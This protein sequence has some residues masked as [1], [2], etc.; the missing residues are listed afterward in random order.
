MELVPT[1]GEFATKLVGTGDGANFAASAG[2]FLSNVLRVL[3]AG[4]V[5]VKNG[6]QAAS[7]VIVAFGTVV[8]RTLGALVSPINRFTEAIGLAFHHLSEGNFREAANAF[9]NIA[10]QVKQDF[11]D[12]GNAISSVVYDQMGEAFADLTE[13]VDEANEA[14]LGVSQSAESTLPPAFKATELA[15]DDAVTVVGDLNEKV[16]WANTAL[17]DLQTEM[18]DG[19]PAA[20]KDMSEAIAAPSTGMTAVMEQAWQNLDTTFQNV[21]TN[22]FETGK[23]SLDSIKDLFLQTLAQMAHQATRPIVMRLGASMGLGGGAAAGGGLFG[24]GIGAFLGDLAMP[25]AI[26]SMIGGNTPA[27]QWG[28]GIGAVGG[29]FATGAIASGIGAMAASGGVFASI[30]G[31][32]GTQALNFII[33]VI[34]P[35][36]GALLGKA[37]GK[38]LA[39]DPEVTFQGSNFA[40]IEEGSLF[41]GFDVRARGGTGPQED[42][43]S[44]AGQAI[45]AIREFD[46]ALGSFMSENQIA[47]IVEAM[48][49]W[50]VNLK[51]SA[52]TIENI[53]E[54]R[55]GVVLS[56]FSRAA[57]DYVRGFDG[58]EAQTQA[59][60]AY[61][62]SNLADLLAGTTDTLTSTQKLSAMAT[63][64][65][66][67][68]AN[69]DGTPEQMRELA[70][71]IDQRYRAEIEYIQAI[72]A[73]VQQIGASI[74]RQ[75]QQLR[76]M[77]GLGAEEL[78]P[79]Q[80]LAQARTAMAGLGAAGSPEEIAAI[81]SRVQ[82]LVQRAAD[83]AGS[84]PEKLAKG[85][86]G[87]TQAD[88]IRQ[89]ILVLDQLE[90]GAVARADVLR[91]AALAESIALREEAAAF[92]EAQ[93]ISLD[94]V[95][96]NT[97]DT[98][99][100]I[101][102]QT[103]VISDGN[104][105]IVDEMNRMNEKFDRLIGLEQDKSDR[106]VIRESLVPAT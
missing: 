35:L 13:G 72:D 15:I 4:V 3:V 47:K 12:A 16:G 57:Q 37:I 53:L 104:A 71:S 70:I 93:Q 94:D 69:F 44:F 21:W 18:S 2:Q 83:A 66:D 27:E 1:L 10:G 100:A 20:A 80:I 84:L 19:V 73:L 106:D 23:L 46:D 61:A 78:T 31:G 48:K 45:A 95:V 7:H 54:S 14:I 50:R 65:R 9:G 97:G 86:F 99:G 49:G 42:P 34:G 30:L 40:P 87:M 52:V 92:A 32:I 90:R 98:I 96:L 88:A 36:I 41:G 82:G 24:G 17:A 26:G 89:A 25:L 11:I 43:N 63:A 103:V 6:F 22:F 60:A 77:I 79:S 5:I 28:S 33:P 67:I 51:N 81:V 105:A 55:F 101:N 75:R 62:R 38:M 8:V 91:E 59:L 76:G 58:L 64:M 56:T 29:M 39:R 68:F 102:D 74:E 85:E